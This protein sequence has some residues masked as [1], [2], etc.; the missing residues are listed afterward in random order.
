MSRTFFA[1]LLIGLA[2]CGSGSTADVSGTVNV[3]GKPV[4]SG[5]VTAIGS[6]KVQHSGPIEE[7]GNYTITGLPP[8]DV[9]FAVASPEPP[10]VA[11]VT[12]TRR[13]K[14]TAISAE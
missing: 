2:G 9:Y 4:C 11:I 8:G 7:N 12:E 13:E 1:L 5:F 6:D 14:R 10:K 3:K